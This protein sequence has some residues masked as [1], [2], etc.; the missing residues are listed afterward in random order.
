MSSPEIRT[1]NVRVYVNDLASY[2][3]KVPEAVFAFTL[4]ELQA[5]E[6]WVP[7][8][9]GFHKEVVE[10]QEEL[11]RLKKESELRQWK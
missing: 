4:D 6:S 2:T 5:L 10:A 11:E 3:K 9:D 7:L 1:R 8:N